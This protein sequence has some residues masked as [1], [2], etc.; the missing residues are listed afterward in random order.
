MCYDEIF[1]ARFVSMLVYIEV[2][3]AKKSSAS[4]GLLDFSVLL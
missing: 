3:S 4:L 1:T 2:V